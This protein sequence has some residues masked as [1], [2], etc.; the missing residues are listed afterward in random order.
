[1]N[2]NESTLET[3]QKTSSWALNEAEDKIRQNWLNQLKVKHLDAF[4]RLGCFELSY[5]DIKICN[6]SFF[7]GGGKCSQ[8]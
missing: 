2:Q 4:T 7:W 8:N 1:M 5:S 3:L 6:L